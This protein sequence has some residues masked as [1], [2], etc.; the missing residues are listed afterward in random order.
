[1]SRV[2]SELVETFKRV[3]AEVSPQLSVEKALQ[4]QNNQLKVNNREYA[5]NQNV[6][7]VAAGKAAVQMVIGAENV[8]KDHVRDGIASIPIRFKVIVPTS[9]KTKFYEAAE[10]NL[11]D[12]LAMQNT[13]KILNFIN[14]PDKSNFINLF[15]ISG[16]ASALLCLPVDG[17]SL[18]DKLSVTKLL[19]SSGADITELNTVRIALSKVKGGQL[20][21]QAVSSTSISLIISDIVG[22][23]IEKVGSGPTVQQHIDL[24]KAKQV[25]MKRGVWEKVPKNV[26]SFL[27]TSPSKN[28]IQQSAGIENVLIC[29]NRILLENFKQQLES[30]GI[31][32][33]IINSELEGNA[34]E[35]GEQFAETLKEWLVGNSAIRPPFN[36]NNIDT[37]TCTRFAWLY[38]GETT[39]QF[40]ADFN[41]PNA[42]GGRNQEMVLA[43]FNKLRIDLANI[44]KLTDRTFY[45][46][47]LGTDG[48]DGPTDATGALIHSDDLSQQDPI[49]DK[50]SEYLN[51]KNSYHFWSNFR[52]SDRLVKIGKTGNNLMDVQLIVFESK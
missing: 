37:S 6:R 26:Q 43:A 31:K 48:Q 49:V 35:V 2:M 23:R 16:G 52:N 51:A 18:E 8:L 50:C 34:Q 21:Q 28:K 22:G 42:K 39:V 46:A 40:P 41:N 36:K 30:N 33:T 4:V 13:E 1:M 19:A 14:I 12:E 47:S 17:V 44:Q 38:G 45:F 15:L 9:L 27:E 7:I 5:L 32:T 10:H 20:V 25:L 11:P 29:D 3:L 24:Q